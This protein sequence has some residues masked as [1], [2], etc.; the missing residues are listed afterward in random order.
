[1]IVPMKKYSFLIY[2]KEYDDFTLKLREL[3]LVHVSLFTNE[4]NKQVENLFKKLE[5]FNEIVRFLNSYKDKDSKEPQAISQDAEQITADIRE[6][7]KL[8]EVKNQQKALS[9]KIIASLLPWGEFSKK[10]FSKLE[11]AGYRAYLFSCP[12]SSF[13]EEWLENFSL[14]K[15]NQVGSNIYFIIFAKKDEL[16][17]LELEEFEAPEKSI[18]ELEQELSTLAKESA[19]IITYFKE[20]SSN[21]TKVLTDEIQRIQDLINLETVKHNTVREVEDKL[22]IMEGWVPEQEAKNVINF[23]EESGVAYFESDPTEEDNTPI[24]LKNNKFSSIFE[25]IA[26]LY[27]LPD[28]KELDLTP[29]FAPFFMLFFGLCLGDAGYGLV[30]LIIATIAKFKVA[31]DFK[32]AMT[33]IQFLGFST[34]VVGFLGGIVF[35][36]QLEN[37]VLTGDNFYFLA[38]ILGIVQILFGLVVKAFNEIKQRGHIYAVSVYGWILILI[39]LVAMGASFLLTNFGGFSASEVASMNLGFIEN[40]AKY[41]FFAGLGLLLFFNNP[42]LSL[43][44]RLGLGLWEFYG[45]TGFL[46]DG[47]SYLRLYALGLASGILGLVIN[48][49]GQ[50]LILEAIPVP[51]LNYLLFAIFLIVAH[52][53]NLLLSAL[54]SFVHPMRL[55]FVEFY[56]NAGW[57]GGGIEYQPFKKTIKTK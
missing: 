56:K 32:P 3:G 9:Q 10:S 39:A 49:L 55:T 54:G 17:E 1:M 35:G 18:S 45:I 22:L 21:F 8:L 44:K 47:L 23:A 4:K 20:N 50:E 24:L 7:I 31:K 43:P 41:V 26:K 46:G 25:P 29:M 38:I 15:I 40:N 6:K 19:E 37:P 14:E 28:Y 53:G 48:Q 16:V 57:T 2:H 52:T 5:D 36:V 51:G 12:E 42:N 34:V 11:E 27:A 13:K 33:L 30:M